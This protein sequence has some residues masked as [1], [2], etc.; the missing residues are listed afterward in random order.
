MSALK[1]LHTADWHLGRRFPTFPEADELKL[2]RARL[3][4]VDEILGKAE[5]YGVDAVLCAGGT[6][7]SSRTTSPP[8]T[9]SISRPCRRFGTFRPKRTGR[10]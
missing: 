5:Y 3:E 4:V 6:R 7:S 10:R 2:T 9:W 8:S 1:L